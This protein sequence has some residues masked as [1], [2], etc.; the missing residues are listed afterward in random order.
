M[1]CIEI[2]LKGFSIQIVV[3]INRNMR[4]IEILQYFEVS[5]LNKSNILK[6]YIKGSTGYQKSSMVKREDKKC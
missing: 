3:V 1:R 2:V 4:C 6:F 5:Y